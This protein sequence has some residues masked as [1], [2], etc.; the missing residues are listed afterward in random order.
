MLNIFQKIFP[1]VQREKKKKEK[2]KSYIPLQNH[3]CNYFIMKLNSHFSIATVLQQKLRCYAK[4]FCVISAL[5]RAQKQEK[6]PYLQLAK[7]V[8]PEQSS[9]AL[10]LLCDDPATPGVP[11][12][13]Y[14][15]SFNYLDQHCCP[16]ALLIRNNLENFPLKEEKDF[17]QLKTN[18]YHHE[19]AIRYLWL[20]HQC[21]ESTV[22]VG[23]PRKGC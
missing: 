8:V 7:S 19:Y 13:T 6:I 10:S 11:T 2:L 23:T 17:A 9:Q 15:T 20:Q 3:Y 5:Y 14:P 16:V 21:K 1:I 12:P 18:I 22:Q 4:Q